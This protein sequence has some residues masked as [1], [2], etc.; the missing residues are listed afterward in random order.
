LSLIL[1][2]PKR[3]GTGAKGITKPITPPPPVEGAELDG[4]SEEKLAPGNGAEGSST[5]FVPQSVARKS[6][7]PS[8]AFRKPMGVGGA[9]K[10]VKPGQVRSKISLFG[11]GTIG[12]IH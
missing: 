9:A 7:Q 11:A 3:S 4:S 2:A 12:S 1:P 5:M 10:S 8:S 6:I